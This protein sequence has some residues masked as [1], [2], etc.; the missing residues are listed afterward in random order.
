VNKRNFFL[1]NIKKAL[2]ESK[3]VTLKNVQCNRPH[4]TLLEHVPGVFIYSGEEDNTKKTGSG[5][6][7]ISTY[8]NIFDI[9]IDVLINTTE[10]AD[11]KLNEYAGEIEDVLNEDIFF[12][13]ITGKEQGDNEGLILRKTSPYNFDD[14]QENLYS[15]VSIQVGVRYIADAISDKKL[16]YLEGVDGEIITTE[17]TENTKPMQIKTNN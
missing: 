7:I 9:K 13:K 10:G 6:F 8:R 5:E 14:G 15:A 17:N 16:K 3:L 4:P 11:L 12:E 1:L 2:K